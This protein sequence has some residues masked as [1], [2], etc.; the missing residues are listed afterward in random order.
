[1]NE[2]LSI[3]MSIQSDLESIITLDHISVT[4]ADPLELR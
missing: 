2:N 4:E 3:R 1:M